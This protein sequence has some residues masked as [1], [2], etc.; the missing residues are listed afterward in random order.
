M[1]E[2]QIFDQY[3]CQNLTQFCTT[4]VTGPPSS[5]TSDQWQGYNQG[6]LTKGERLC[7]VDLLNKGNLFYKIMQANSKETN[8]IRLVQGGQLYQA[9][10]FSKGSLVKKN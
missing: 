8:I 7:T 5:V 3:L 2:C 4:K 6:T 10:S 1:C 9:F